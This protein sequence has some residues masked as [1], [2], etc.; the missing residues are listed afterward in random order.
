MKE[1]LNT[2]RRFS[3]ELVLSETSL[4]PSSGFS[5]RGTAAASFLRKVIGTILASLIALPHAACTA[6]QDILDP[7]FGHDGRVTTDFSGS[8]DEASAV[9]IQSDGNIVAAGVAETSDSNFDFALARYDRTGALDTSFG[10]AGRVTTDFSANRDFAHDCAIQSDGKIVAAGSAYK[11]DSNFDFALARYDRTGTLDTNFGTAGKV[12][13]D[14]SELS[15]EVRAV[16]SFCLET[17]ETGVVGGFAEDLA[18]RF[19]DSRGRSR[20]KSPVFRA[21]W[22]D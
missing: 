1:Q 6:P 5:L 19:S 3:L 18:R 11:P 20:G 12:T 16:A 8:F 13:T 4:P 17:A 9:A 10:T 2:R 7:A 14:F 15:E 21:N 22:A